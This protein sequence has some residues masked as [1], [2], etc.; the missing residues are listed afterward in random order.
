MVKNNMNKEE[1]L[2]K[3]IEKAVKNNW[4]I[5]NQKVV[6]YEI[7]EFDN[8]FLF[9]NDINIQFDIFEIIFSHD[10][11]KAFWGEEEIEVEIVENFIGK[12]NND[13]IYYYQSSWRYHL[14]QMILEEDP[15]KYLEKFL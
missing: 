3:A 12:K 1:I 8:I 15:I 13:H 6:D 9:W 10:F 7:D 5:V 2:K 14:Q 4:E 11:A